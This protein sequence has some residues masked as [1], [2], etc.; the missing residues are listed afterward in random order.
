MFSAEFWQAWALSSIRYS[1]SQKPAQQACLDRTFLAIEESTYGSLA[2]DV[3]R[4]AWK[5]IAR[6]KKIVERSIS[7]DSKNF[8]RRLE[9]RFVADQPALDFSEM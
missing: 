5:A 9:E 8:T 7:W 6:N 3:A 2:S 1:S 4:H